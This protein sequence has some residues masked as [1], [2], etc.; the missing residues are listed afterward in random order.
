VVRVEKNPFFFKKLNPPAFLFFLK[1]QRFFGFFKK[2]QD[3]IHFFK[4][5]EK[6]HSDLFSFHHAI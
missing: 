1:K 4:K 2:K 5:T 6:P 3:F